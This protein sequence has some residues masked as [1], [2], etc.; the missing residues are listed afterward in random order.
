M[1]DG[2]IAASTVNDRRRQH[3]PSPMDLTYRSADGWLERYSRRRHGRWT[4]LG[5]PLDGPTEHDRTEALS[6]IPAVLRVRRRVVPVWTPG[7]AA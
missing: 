7:S 2:L 5:T 1:I 4:A 6:R 3:Y